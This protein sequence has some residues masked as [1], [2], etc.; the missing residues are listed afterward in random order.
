VS[1]GILNTCLR[2]ISAFRSIEKGKFP[3]REGEQWCGRESLQIE[4]VHPSSRG[5]SNSSKGGIVELESSL[6]TPNYVRDCLAGNDDQY[7]ERIVKRYDFFAPRLPGY[8]RVV[9]V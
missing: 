6:N 9:C 7:P 3:Y 5:I 4:L 8:Y 2:L 1:V